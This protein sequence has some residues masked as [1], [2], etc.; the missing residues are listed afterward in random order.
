MAEGEAVSPDRLREPL[1]GIDPEVLQQIMPLTGGVIT[2]MFTDIVDSTKV[3]PRSETGTI[4]TTF[5]RHIT[6]LCGSAFRPT[7]AV[8]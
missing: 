3:R 6:R 2:M 4:S 7:T 8:S 5:S 1:A